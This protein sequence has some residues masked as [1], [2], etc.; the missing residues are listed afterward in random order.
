MP[1]HIMTEIVDRDIT[2]R[3]S[4]NVGKRMQLTKGDG[5]IDVPSEF[6]MSI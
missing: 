4:A 5:G 6:Y 1:K 3:K 2:S